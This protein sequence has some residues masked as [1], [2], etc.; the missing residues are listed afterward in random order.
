MRANL[1]YIFGSVW[2][3]EGQGDYLNVCSV[4]SSNNSPVGMDGNHLT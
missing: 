4:R 1:L 3:V 2:G